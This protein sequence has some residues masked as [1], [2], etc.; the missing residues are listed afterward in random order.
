MSTRK[1]V[2]ISNT[3]ESSNASSGALIISGGIGIYNSTDA[4]SP[5]QG[6][7]LTISGG[8]AVGKKLFVGSDIYFSGNLY[9]NGTPFVS[10]SA[11]ES[12]WVSN[13][14]DNDISYTS[15]TVTMFNQNV[16][17]ST[18]GNLTTSNIK[19]TKGFPI[20]N[21][22][23]VLP[24][25]FT[26]AVSKRELVIAHRFGHLCQPTYSVK[27][28]VR[29]IEQGVRFVEID[30]ATTT[31]GVFYITHFN[32]NTAEEYDATDLP[33]SVT[34][35][36]L[37]DAFI[38]RGNPSTRFPESLPT[39][40]EFWS[41]VKNYDIIIVIELKNG[42]AAN[43][44]SKMKE[45]GMG[46]SRVIFSDRDKDD[47]LLMKQ[48]GF[49][50][51]YDTTSTL[52]GYWDSLTTEEKNLM[53]YIAC[54]KTL[55]STVNAIG[56]PFVIYTLLS[57]AEWSEYRS[58]YSNLVGCYTDVPLPTIHYNNKKSDD[59]FLTLLNPENGFVAHLQATSTNKYNKAWLNFD[60]PTVRLNVNKGVTS[61]GV[62][63][64]QF[65][66]YKLAN[67][68]YGKVYIPEGSTV[69][70]LAWFGFCVRCNEDY[71]E[72]DSSPE[73]SGLRKSG[74]NV[75]MRRNGSIELHELSEGTVVTRATSTG[76]TD[77]ANFEV[78]WGF[79]REI[80]NGQA[81]VYLKLSV[82]AADVVNPKV[83]PTVTYTFTNTTLASSDIYL[84][85]L[86]RPN[87][88]TSVLTGFME[89]SPYNYIDK[90]IKF[91]S[92]GNVG[93]GTIAPAYTLDVSG[94][95]EVAN[96]AGSSSVII[97]STPSES[98]FNILQ[99]SHYKR[100]FVRDSDKIFGIFNNDSGQNRTQ[101]KIITGTGAT[102]DKLAL[103]EA[104]GNVGIGTTNALAPLHVINGHIVANSSLPG[105]RKAYINTLSNNSVIMPTVQNTSELFF[106]YKDSSGVPRQLWINPSA[107]GGNALFTGQHMNYVDEN[108]LP[109]DPRIHEGL[110]VCSVSKYRSYDPILQQPIEN[111]IS[112]NESLPVIKLSSAPNE[113]SVFGVVTSH[114]NNPLKRENGTIVFDNDEYDFERDIGGRIR[115]NSVGEGGVWVCNQNGNLQNGDYITTSGLPG[116]GMKQEDDFLHN[117]TVAKITCDC[118]FTNLPNYIQT[119]DLVHNGFL[120][121]CAFVGCTY[122]CG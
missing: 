119:R 61:N 23:E 111:K 24:P 14:N 13:E 55:A 94:N 101:F 46:T 122:H 81:V 104:G 118:D 45:I 84:T 73:E 16:T 37:K 12:L 82:K 7:G 22:I 5:S 109:L 31:D 117:Y 18:I 64:Y 100:F 70:N 99:S 63:A 25:F 28:I 35:M 120:Y 68:F 90:R 71:R 1:T 115:I 106:Y 32:N 83:S 40:E 54:S 67:Q 113:K 95:F 6:G 85:L 79:L 69:T 59:R 112:I 44:I 58:L 17:N 3:R 33:T 77:L 30:L 121:K 47:V 42:S 57:P 96:T 80:V 103:L 43:L 60:Y 92:D 93:I 105:D 107:F 20:S 50:V 4:L 91:L 27:S 11:Q 38:M 76:N 108:L 114:S 62:A 110:V 2:Y 8:A 78:Y 15:G 48:A 36:S 87:S 89:Y 53:D 29:Q 74:I 52:T 97:N 116:Y 34:E 72:V 49:T 86:S 51:M 41:L 75:I 39:L 65:H 66:N 10:G 26:N 21:R 56:K 19:D 98:H 9:Q 102:N 88:T